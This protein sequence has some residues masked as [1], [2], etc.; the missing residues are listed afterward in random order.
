M[1]LIPGGR[2]PASA[3]RTHGTGTFNVGTNVTL[4]ATAKAGFVF[5]NWTDGLTVV[6]DMPRFSFLLDS[7]RTFV[8]NFHRE[9]VITT[10]SLPVAGGTTTGAGTFNSGSS[11]ALTAT[12]NPGFAFDKWTFRAS[13][14]STGS[15]YTFVAAQSRDMVANF[16]PTY[17]V[18]PVALPSIGGTVIGGGTYK[19]GTK[20][21]L[22]AKSVAGYR[23]TS[24]S[25]AGVIVSTVPRYTITVSA[26]HTLE[27]NFT[28]R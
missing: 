7:N 1:D 19:Q 5:S 27:A 16:L 10:A 14:A 13:T 11:V 20:A 25:E 9:C 12:A 17:T 2:S 26:N 8:A 3:G 24:W 15:S 4:G 18:S 6:S 22:I 28:K 21:L 23:F